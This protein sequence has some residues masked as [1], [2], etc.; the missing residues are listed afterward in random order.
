MP[1]AD[2][3]RLRRLAL[4]A[5]PGPWEHYHSPTRRGLTPTNEIRA[6]KR[7]RPV[8]HWTGF[9]DSDVSGEQHAANA[10]FIAACDP[11]TIL[12]LLAT[13][14]DAGERAGVPTKPGFYWWRTKYDGPKVKEV[15]RGCIFNEN[16]GKL[17]AVWQ[18]NLVEVGQMSGEWF[19]PLL[20]PW[21]VPEIVSIPIPDEYTRAGEK[22]MKSVRADRPPG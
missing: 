16:V 2:L 5:T 10:A 3:E 19:G 13:R 22:L 6:T 21:P 8:I 1:Q 12:A 18:G 14:T 15:T 17:L 11:Q 9:D 7:K 20:S 4:A